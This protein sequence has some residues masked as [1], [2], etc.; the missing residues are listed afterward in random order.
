M[1]IYIY[2]LHTTVFSIVFSNVSLA[3]VCT[4]STLNIQPVIFIYVWK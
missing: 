2:I 4:L 1:Y 3:L